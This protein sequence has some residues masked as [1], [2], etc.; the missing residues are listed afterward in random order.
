M[1]RQSQRVPCLA[2]N[3]TCRFCR[4]KGHFLKVYMSRNVKQLHEIVDSPDYEGQDMHLRTDDYAKFAVNTFTYE[5]DGSSD[6]EA[7]RV[8]LGTVSTENALHSLDSHQNRI[9]RSVRLNDQCNVKMKIDTD[10]D[11]CI[12]TADDLPIL[13]ISS[14][15]QLSDSILKG[16]NTSESQRLKSLMETNQWK[17]SSM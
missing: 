10:A 14:D 6:T 8:I 9:Y 3:A 2:L 4:K 1:W 17:Q 13:P 5:E 16:Y 15:L 11:T 7:R 12:L